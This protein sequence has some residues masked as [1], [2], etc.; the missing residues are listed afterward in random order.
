MVGEDGEN[1]VF[2]R[3]A[4][5]E[6]AH[7]FE[8]DGFGDFDK[9]ETGTDEVGVFGGA[10]APRQGVGCAAHARVG[11]SGLDEITDLNEFLSCDLVAN[12]R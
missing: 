7:E 4:V 6:F 8:A 9:R 1:D 12:T 3:A 5:V 2:G 10:Y 11:V